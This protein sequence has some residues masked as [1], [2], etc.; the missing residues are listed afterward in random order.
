MVVQGLEPL[1][2]GRVIHGA[3]FERGC[4]PASPLRQQEL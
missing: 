1:A 4:L 3:V 2:D